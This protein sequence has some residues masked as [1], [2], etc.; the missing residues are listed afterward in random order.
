LWSE[1][2]L[3]RRILNP[4]KVKSILRMHSEP[5]EPLPLP[6]GTAG[7]MGDKE[8]GADDPAELESGMKP[9]AC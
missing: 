4:A 8:N 5:S 6:P 9:I 3:G 2:I 1:L 7:V